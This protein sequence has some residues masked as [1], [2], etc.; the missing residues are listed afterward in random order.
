MSV[1]ATIVLYDDLMI[2]TETDIEYHQEKQLTDFVKSLF[3]DMREA[4]RAEVY[5]R[6]TGTILYRYRKSS[7]KRIVSKDT[8]VKRRPYY[9]GGRRRMG[10]NKPMLFRADKEVCDILN[11]LCTYA[12]S[13]YIRAAIKEK[14][15]RE[16][17]C[18]TK[19]PTDDASKE[20]AEET[21]KM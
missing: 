21:P 4:E 1:T 3:M 14:Y 18:G 9:G 8:S 19:S 5:D 11:T 17:S 16:L 15:E 6:K 20:A 13:S 7:G 10:Q 12:K 2:V